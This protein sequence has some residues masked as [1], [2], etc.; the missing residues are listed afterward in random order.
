MKVLMLA[1]EPFFEPR[2]TPISVYQ[3]LR[4]LSRLG[5]EVD[6]VTYHVGEDVQISNVTIARI[7]SVPFVH[8]VK[9]GPS[10]AKIVLDAVLFFKAFALLL[11]RRYDVIHSHEEASFIG[12]LLAALFQTMHIYDMHSSLP[13]QL[14]NLGYG[15]NG[16][17]V[18]LFRWAERWTLNTSDAVITI[19]EELTEYV[20][21]INPRLVVEQ[22]DNMPINIGASGTELGAQYHAIR[23]QLRA[24][25]R[26]AVIYT[27]TFEP[28]QG[29]ESLIQMA[30]LLPH[31]VADRVTFVLV[32]GKPYQTEALQAEIERL[33][34]RSQ[35]VLTGS[36][37]L[38]D[39]FAYLGLGEVLI[40]PRIMDTSVPLKIYSYL[41]AQRAILATRI[42]A[43][44]QVLSDEFS[45]LV[46]PDPASLADGLT[47]L[48]EDDDLRPRLAGRAREHALKHYDP[49]R[50]LSKVEGLYSRLIPRARPAEPAPS[51]TE[52]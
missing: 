24:D 13:R 9:V 40:S 31:A 44:T 16:P 29:L 7:P 4:A 10:L 42:R 33:Q 26:L 12:M 30:M 46:D 6:L 18:L 15:P 23:D 20:R 8:Q 34:P 11:R 5:H 52:H 2:G 38:D 28:Y 35:F 39:A 17:V 32:G 43:H 50:Y 1:P 49:A 48:V 27:G 36:V 47:R 22:I 21:G 3:R 37:P 41:H 51:P 25:G 19:D 45:L 14:M